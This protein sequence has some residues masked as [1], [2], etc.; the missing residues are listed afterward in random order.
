MLSCFI[1]EFT[2]YCKNLSYAENS[3]K[4]LLRY[5]NNFNDFLIDKQV[6]DLS[7][8]KY[9]HLLNFVTSQPASPHTV[10]ARIWALKKFFCFLHLQEH[11]N[12]N[13]SKDLKPPKIPQKETAFL[14]ANELKIVIGHLVKN[15]Y[16]TNGMRD[17]LIISLMAILGLRKSSVV[18]LNV[19]DLDTINQRIF[20]LEKGVKSKRPILIPLA[21]F[22]LLHEYITRNNITDG[23][24]F[25]SRNKKRLRADAV[26]KIVGNIKKSLLSD[27][28]Q[29]AQN[30]HPHIFRHSAATELN[31]IAG[32]DITRELLGHRNIQNTRKYI[33]LSPTSYG[34]YMK[35]HP[36]FYH[37]R[38]LT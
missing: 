23:P 34:D 30:L 20:V 18:A 13:I 32:F 6:N 27:E 7:Q 4:E 14:T 36:Y 24:L 26:D 29:F 10:K 1:Y 21:I 16:Q 2:T 33:H 5:I 28:H 8:L 11:I 19:K 38:S 15:I 22:D 31:D 35:R 12:D 3:V 17:F 37:E 25:L 9:I